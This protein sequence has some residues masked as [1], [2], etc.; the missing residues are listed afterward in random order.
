MCLV[1]RSRL[2]IFPR[3]ENSLKI[4]LNVNKISWI[5]LKDFV[6]FLDLISW[7]FELRKAME[8]FRVTLNRRCLI[9]FFTFNTCS[10]TVDGRLWLQSIFVEKRNSDELNVNFN[11][12]EDE[13]HAKQMSYR[14]DEADKTAAHC[15]KYE[16]CV[17]HKVRNEET[18]LR[19]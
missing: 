14:S 2:I 17:E 15:Q 11:R 5:Y 4:L 16:D 1:S 7:K 9:F 13:R 10:F 18:C 6:Y 3:Q 19:L 8:N 12:Q